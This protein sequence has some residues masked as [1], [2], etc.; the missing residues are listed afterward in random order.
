VTTNGNER[1]A[2]KTMHGFQRKRD[3]GREAALRSELTMGANMPSAAASAIRYGHI[4]RVLVRP[5]SL[6]CLIPVIL[7]ATASPCPQV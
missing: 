7:Q 1:R 6:R 5:A 2:S 4:W 3:M